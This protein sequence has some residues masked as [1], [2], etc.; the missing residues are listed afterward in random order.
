[1]RTKFRS[2]WKDTV[3]PLEVIGVLSILII[4]I[5]LIYLV[6]R[7]YGTGLDGYTQI[8]VARTTGATTRTEILQPGK[9]LWDWLQLLIIPV[10][11]AIAGYLF[12]LTVSRNEQ[13]S[14]QLRD[15]TEREISSDNQRESALQQYIDKMS[16]HLLAN[17]LRKSSQEDEVRNIARVRTLT[18]LPRLDASRKRSILLFLYESS[19]I[20]KSKPIIDLKDADLYGAY[21]SNAKLSN[22]KLSNAKLNVA[23][24]SGADLSG[25]DLSGADLT[26]ANLSDADLSNADLSRG[27]LHRVNLSNANLS[28]ADL[29]NANL[30]GVKLYGADLSGADLRF[31]KLRFAK[32]HRVNLSNSDLSGVNLDRA[33]L[34]GANLSGANLS[35]ANLSG[36]NLSGANLSG[37][38]LSGANLSGAT[39]TT[40]ELNTAVSLTNTTMP[41]GSKHL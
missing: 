40:E 9:T 3:K 21:L 1:M 16:E 20:E 27:E 26:E 8:Q 15:Q 31:A 32:L 13:K 23:D 12:N 7:F 37:A 10:V 19:L 34:S 4:G 18:V 38:N 14:T 2:W 25:A 22:S 35:G 6:A 24:L 29:S 41:D 36:A 28:D 30:S 39:I 17:K 5:V 11:L 33:N